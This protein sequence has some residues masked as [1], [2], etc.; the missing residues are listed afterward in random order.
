[1]NRRRALRSH[2]PELAAALFLSLQGAA[3][4]LT[5]GQG[6]G[7]GT[8]PAILTAAAALGTVAAAWRPAFSLAGARRAAWRLL[9]A[10]QAALLLAAMGW[11]LQEGGGPDEAAHRQALEAAAASERGAVAQLESALNDLAEVAAARTVADPFDLARDLETLWQKAG[12]GGGAYPLGVAIWLSGER[13]AWGERVAPLPPPAPAGPTAW[14]WV[15]AGR[16]AWYWRR[17]KTL[18]R[19]GGD[20][21]LELQARLAPTAEPRHGFGDPPVPAAAEARRLRRE[22]VTGRDP[23]VPPAFAGILA[24][25]SVELP[26]PDATAE[27]AA[28]ALRVTAQGPPAA[29]QARR[30]SARALLLGLLCWSA[31]ALAW[32]RAA[33]GQM[34]LLAA[35]WVARGLL[36]AVDL[37]RWAHAAFPRG[38]SPARTAEWASLV[39]PAY[40]ATTAAAG[41]FASAADAAVTA[42]VFALTALT[43][44][45]RWSRPDPGQTRPRWLPLLCALAAAP[46]LLALRELVFTFVENANPRLIG[47]RAPF[48]FL[49]FWVLHLA[50]LLFAGGAALLVQTSAAGMLRTAR[51][52][53]VA[54]VSLGL[55]LAA[56]LAL[57]GMSAATRFLLPSLV[58]LLWAGAALARAEAAELRRLALLAPLLAAV[59][60]N[61]G[62][63]AE[64]YGRAEAAW[65]QRK[66]DEIVQPQEELMSFLLE[67][68]LADMQAAETE[69]LPQASRITPGSGDLWQDWPAYELWRRSAIH[70]LGLPCLVEIVDAGGRVES[71]FA[72]GFFR[73]YGYEVAGRSEWSTAEAFLLQT[74][75]RRYPGGEEVIMRGEAPRLDRPGWIRLEL[76]LHSRRLR[77]L[78][79]RLEGG[80]VEPATG[81]YQPRAEIDRPLL[82]LRGDA[83]GWLDAGPAQF[84]ELPPA[85]VV[86]SLRDGAA[87]G[88]KVRIGST[89]Y[90]CLWKAA[91]QPAAGHPGEGYLIGLEI[92]S[93]V[94]RLLDVSRL[95]LLSLLLLGAL[96]CPPLLA[97]LAMRRDAAVLGFQERI[98]LATLL[99]GLLPLLLA[100]S[101]VDRLTL[102]GLA[103][104]ARDQTRDGLEAALAQLQGLLGQQARALAG[105]EYIADLLASRLAGQRPLGPYA[106]RQGMVFAGDGR[107]LLDETLSDLDAAEAA[108]LLASAREGPLVVMRDEGSLF[109]GLAIPVDLSDVVP[110]DAF[111][112]VGDEDAE[113]VDQHPE[114][115]PN[116]WFFYRQRV[117]ADLL[118][119]LAEIV[120]G[121][122]TLRVGGETVLSSEPA[123]VF[124]GAAPLLMPPAVGRGLLRHPASPYL[125]ATPGT[126]LAF[127]GAQA[128]PSLALEQDGEGLRRRAVPA[129]LAVTFP[130]REREFAR[131]RE[132]TI[133]LLAGLATMIFLATALLG[134][135]LT[136]RIFGPVRVLVTA[137]RRLAAGDYTAPLPEEGRHEVGALS[138][139]FRSMRDELERAQRA[140]A[141]RERFLATVL[142]RVPVGVAIFGA[143]EGLAALNQ[144][145]QALLGVSAAE[146]AQA[147]QESARDLL[148]RCRRLL[149]GAAHG[150]GELTEPETR[151]TLRIRLAPLR[152][153]DGRDDTMLVF[154]DV[155][156]F[157][158]NQRLAM[159]AELARQ[160]AHE[161]KNPL[162][163]IQLSVQFLDQARRDR[164][165]DLDQIIRQTVEQVLQQ[166]SLLRTIATEFS[167]LGR[168]EDLVCAPL[169]LP[170]LVRE[171]TARYRAQIVAVPADGGGA[172]VAP[173]G[174]EA[175]PTTPA[176]AGPRVEIT[177]GAV[178]AV[179][180]HADSLGKVIGNLMEN[181]L[182]ACGE[183]GALVV[184]VGWRVEAGEVALLWEDNGPGL[185]PEVAARLFDPYFSTKSKGTGLGLAICRS[186]LGKMGGRISLRNREGGGAIAVVVLP[187]A[188]LEE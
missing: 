74:E 12:P 121:E 99:L 26:L 184:R 44:A 177:A 97:R 73:D 116:G 180:G 69:A 81:S 70:D 172:A 78:L 123:R 173:V 110:P 115:R 71:L 145:A 106:A 37:P 178:P 188:P 6:K 131:Q 18:S 152:L 5:G 20:H 92:P 133:L 49:S 47:P 127:T 29:E 30:A 103:D 52:G 96:A 153:P 46:A 142:D 94:D 75:R 136:W 64:A 166:V 56:A 77:T 134:L 104:A 50:L 154:E 148:Q 108:L 48:R 89:V 60:W 107:L 31:S 58:A 120:Q 183:A 59:L 87:R 28:V 141:Q 61:Y 163:P 135:V 76:P 9:A 150:A 90:R 23:A 35:A 3:F 98:L 34:G 149:G 125:A 82:L 117:D 170:G 100:G 11:A 25:S 179:L 36:V 45:A 83:T 66:G 91:P 162:T 55:A 124:S 42:A 165:A 129:V 80:A 53:L 88:G 118:G 176:G 41:L 169:D 14:G 143:G 13:V 33:L 182:Q 72:A 146:S 147:R 2:A 126:R 158:A 19:S 54:A 119:G 21:V 63:L 175:A 185:A 151:R 139:A 144:A 95:L 1:M 7:T 138:A 187:R 24:S 113:G 137:T 186:L 157:L 171:V 102:R 16:E 67:D 22:I 62:G 15:E 51:G 40:F 109:L 122:V 159:N 132:Q 161:I 65:L 167:L 101:F 38:Q 168:P 68:A 111:A 112:G 86:E 17:F 181:S 140:L 8:L 114:R 160:V 39:D 85:A 164:A 174:A 79:A 105:S 156:E 93:L 128:L 57:P 84:P 43:L 27:G 32:G 10:L 155:T 4:L 130:A